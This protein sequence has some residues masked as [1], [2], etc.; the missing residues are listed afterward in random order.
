LRCAFS[1]A[2]LVLMTAAMM[3][4]LLVLGFDELRLH[5]RQRWSPL[6]ADRCCWY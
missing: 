1:E 6:I 4:L 2:M 5:C 3:I